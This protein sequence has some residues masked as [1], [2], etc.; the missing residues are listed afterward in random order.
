MRQEKEVLVSFLPSGLSGSGGHSN[1]LLD[2]VEREEGGA[3][4]LLNSQEPSAHSS[5]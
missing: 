5:C 2:P 4:A 1:Y 3:L